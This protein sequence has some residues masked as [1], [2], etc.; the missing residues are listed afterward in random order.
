[1]ETNLEY[2]PTALITVA[3]LV[4]LLVG[5]SIFVTNNVIETFKQ[6]GNSLDIFC[7]ETPILYSTEIHIF[8]TTIYCQI[9]ET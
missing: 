9:T 6:R 3:V 7:S 4:I 1:M 8:E 2:L 5:A